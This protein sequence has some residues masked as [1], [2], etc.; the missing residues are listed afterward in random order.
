M[1]SDGI[2]LH[3]MQKVRPSNPS[4]RIE[5]REYDAHLTEGRYRL[6]RGDQVTAEVASAKS[7]GVS[8][9]GHA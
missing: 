8:D 2:V 6:G 9:R 7:P 3:G 5:L 4:L 1:P